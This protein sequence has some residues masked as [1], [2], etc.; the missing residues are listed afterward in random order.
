MANSQYNILS[1]NFNRI[2]LLQIANGTLPNG[3]DYK[4]S[5]N[6]KLEKSLHPLTSDKKQSYEEIPLHTACLTYLGFYLLMFLGYINRI[7]FTPKIA[8]EKNRE[9]SEINIII[10]NEIYNQG[11]QKNRTV[12]IKY[13]DMT[14]V[15]PVTLMRMA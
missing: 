11:K 12:T 9:V 15:Y 10:E 2:A 1:I 13:V 5:S 6:E 4:Q 3:F 8:T 7:F 14:Y